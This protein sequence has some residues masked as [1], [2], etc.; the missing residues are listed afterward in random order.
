MVID[1]DNLI[2]PIFNFDIEF[3]T[4]HRVWKINS[5]KP[6]I[7]NH[8]IVGDAGYRLNEVWTKP[9]SEAELNYE[10][11]PTCLHNNLIYNN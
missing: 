5:V 6:I 7:D 1:S 2:Y 10:V 3:S 11:D 8:I 4:W 9:Y